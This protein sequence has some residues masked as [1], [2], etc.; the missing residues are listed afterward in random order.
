M[1][2]VLLEAHELHTYYGAS[3]VLHGI[4]IDVRAGEVGWPPV[5]SSTGACL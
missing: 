4:D 3:H 2:D 1:A 5:T